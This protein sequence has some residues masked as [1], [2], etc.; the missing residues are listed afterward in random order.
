MPPPMLHVEILRPEAAI[1]FD[2]LKGAPELSGFTLMGGTALALQAGHRVSLDFDF[3]VFDERLPAARIDRLIERLKEAGHAARLITDS[4]Q[5]SQFK[6][7]TGERLLDFARDYV[8]DSVKVTFFAHGKTERQRAF[9]REAEK[10]QEPGMEFNILGIEGLKATKTLVLADRVRS[11]DLY[12]VF[13]LV[14]EHGLTVA[15]IEATARTL[16]T[17]DDPEHYKSVLRGQIPLDRDDEGLEP[18]GIQMPVAELYERFEGT[19][20]EHETEQAR[21]FFVSHPD[22]R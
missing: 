8:I 12:D 15:E 22:R 11:R 18:V 1:L 20:A 10:V 3:A 5:I 2:V 4:G 13:V 16:G 21:R 14:R 17:I 9:Y 6:I 19:I 7:N